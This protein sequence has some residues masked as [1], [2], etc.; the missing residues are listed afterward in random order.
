MAFRSGA[1][2]C[3]AKKTIGGYLCVDERAGFRAPALKAIQRGVRQVTTDWL[4]INA[5][6]SAR[7]VSSSQE[8]G[9][10]RPLSRG[11]RSASSSKV[12]LSA[13]RGCAT[14]TAPSGPQAASNCMPGAAGGFWMSNRSKRWTWSRCACWDD[15]RRRN[16]R[17]ACVRRRGGDRASVWRC[18]V[19]TGD[20][21]AGRTCLPR[22][23][24]RSGGNRPSPSER[25]RPPGG[26]V[27]PAGKGPGAHGSQDLVRTFGREE[28]NAVQVPC[29]SSKPSI[30][31]AAFPRKSPA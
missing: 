16:R 10:S 12:M 29:S 2:R 9:P 1:E 31:T 23:W 11:Y 28:G 21:R 6:G 3:R 7:M 19:P 15:H 14:Q 25:R 5:R 27:D 30:C 18:C 26:P 22:H 8:R 17:A 24:C 13:I 4:R 20:S